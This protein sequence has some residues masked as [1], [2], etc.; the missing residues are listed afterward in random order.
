M[1]V[2]KK[3]FYNFILIL[4][5]LFFIDRLSKIIILNYFETSLETYIKITSFLNLVLVWN[6]GV[7]FGLFSFEENIAYNIITFFVLLVIILIFYL[8]LKTNDIKFYFYLIIIGGALGNFFDRILYSAVPDFI[9]FHIGNFHWFV[10]NIAD[11]FITVGIICLII[12]EIMLNKE[13]NEK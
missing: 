1:T 2:F 6:S 9:D 8:S 13:I 7:G 3:K 12:A 11:I 5:L 4:P 10:F